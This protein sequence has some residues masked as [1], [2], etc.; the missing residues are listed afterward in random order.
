MRRREGPGWWKKD[1]ISQSNSTFSPLFPG[2]DWA[3]QSSTCIHIHCAVSDCLESG[4]HGLLLYVTFF[5]SYSVLCRPH[6]VKPLTFPKT[7]ADAGIPGQQGVSAVEAQDQ[8][9]CQ[10]EDGEGVGYS[11]VT[12]CW[13]H[14]TYPLQKQKQ[15]LKYVMPAQSWNKNFHQ[16]EPPHVPPTSHCA[17]PCDR[18]PFPSLSSSPYTPAETDSLRQT[19][20]KHTLSN[21]L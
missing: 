15:S 4:S 14:T 7:V 10:A 5:Y 16:F 17:S 20:N 21:E 13:L 1:L 2:L 19:Q 11:I 3:S 8:H 9:V 18:C 6:K 12:G